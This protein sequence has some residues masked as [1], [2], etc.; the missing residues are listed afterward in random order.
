MATKTKKRRVW[1]SEMKAKIVDEANTNGVAAAA[2]KYKLSE[3][4]IYT[5]KSRTRAAAPRTRK[6]TRTRKVR[7]VTTNVQEAHARKVAAE[8]MQLRNLV[9]DQLLEIKRLQK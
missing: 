7:N 8:N 2:K 4:S 6:V 3:A 1:T 5:W 9:I